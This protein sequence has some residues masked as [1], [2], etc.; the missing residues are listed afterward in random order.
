MHMR[1][2]RLIVAHG[3]EV[4][5]EDEISECASVSFVV[6]HLLHDDEVSVLAWTVSVIHCSAHRN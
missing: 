5:R 4:V 3:G 6:T 1:M 2:V